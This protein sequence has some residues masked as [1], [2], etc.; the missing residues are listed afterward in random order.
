MKTIYNIL[1]LLFAAILLTTCNGGNGDDNGDGDDGESDLEISWVTDSGDPIATGDYDS[2]ILTGYSCFG[3]FEVDS[4]SGEIEMSALLKDNAG[5]TVES[6]TE[7]FNVEEGQS[8]KL[9]M[10]VN[11]FGPSNYDPGN[12]P[13]GFPN[14]F[15]VT[16]STPSSSEDNQI[17]IQ[18]GFYTDSLSCGQLS[19]ESWTDTDTTWTLTAKVLPEGSGSV[20]DNLGLLVYEG[21]RPNRSGEF[22]VGE[23]DHGAEI[24][25]TATPATGYVFD[26]WYGTWWTNR[27]TDPSVTF[28]VEV[29]ILIEAHF[30]AE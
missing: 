6:Q 2:G 20:S 11:C 17:N 18:G 28:T 27:P 25:L 16:F 10:M 30:L 7:P 12:P 19:L 4:G 1:V 8:Y 9:T 26:H 14:D 23:Y 3:Y 13:P 5:N 29:P 15:S 21:T 24:T 22:Y